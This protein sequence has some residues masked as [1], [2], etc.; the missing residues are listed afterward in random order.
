MSNFLAVATVTETLR[1]MLNSAVSRDI[2]GGARATAVRPA[3]PDKS[4][5]SGLPESGVNIFLYQINFNA[6]RRNSDLPNRRAD[7]S[8]MQR[9]KV[10]LDLNYLLTFYGDEKQ[11]E[12]QRI[13][14][15]VVSAL[16]SHP[17][18][19]RSQIE[20]ALQS[21]DVLSESDLAEEPESA[22]I[23][24]LHLTIDEM[25]NL[26]SG[27]F[28]SPY[29]LSVAYQVSVIFIEGRETAQE[30]LP[31]QRF[32]I[33]ANIFR[34][35]F[36]EN[37]S[38][39]DDMGRVQP[40]VQDSCLLLRGRNL[41]GPVTWVRVGSAVVSPLQVQDDCI[42]IRLSDP[43]FPK[44]SL[45]AGIISL[46]VI[47]ET[48]LGD[49]PVP[50][51]G[52]ESNAAAFVLRPLV[53]Q[54]SLVSSRKTT[55]GR[56]SGEILLRFRPILGKGQKAVL[57]LNEIVA[58]KIGRMD[59]RAGETPRRGGVAYTFRSQ[60]RA[61]DLE[62]VTFAFENVKA[63]AYSVRLQVDGEQSPLFLD[64]D[65]SSPTYGLYV[66]PSVAISGSA[67]ER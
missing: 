6:E 31:V 64:D 66:K 18:L 50:H 5:T 27:F 23:T 48:L 13:L 45:R 17:V 21:Y 59:A 26:W 57:F 47:H 12:P 11:L 49:P 41:L 39:P 51:H 20:T 14:G 34:E 24:P 28:Q 60:G 36:I 52:F 2:S 35:P 37:V 63:G 10:A 58:D 4:S 40:I 62:E 19:S 32:S 15:S 7:G 25:H 43:P 1:Q 55:D 67:G 42:K 8:V 9:P 54:S 53:S 33:N 16:H 29:V 61:A 38:Q 44:G 56:I 46:Q 30:A 3:A 22:K 65:I